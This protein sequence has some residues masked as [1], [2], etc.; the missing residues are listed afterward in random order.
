MIVEFERQHLS[1]PGH[2]RRDIS[3]SPSGLSY[4][5][6]RTWVVYASVPSKLRALMSRELVPCCLVPKACCRLCS[7]PRQQPR[8]AMELV[9]SRS[10][11]CTAPLLNKHSISPLFIRQDLHS[12]AVGDWKTLE[13]PTIDL[14]SISPDNRA[15]SGRTA[16]LCRR[17]GVLNQ[18]NR[19]IVRH[20][21]LLRTWHGS[22]PH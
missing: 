14:S 11:R 22:W 8:G 6:T 20:L 7:P 9:Y 18:D 17:V 2:S 16:L 3:F 15:V 21:N 13:S 4:A 12:C 5:D 1:P 10:S 19:N